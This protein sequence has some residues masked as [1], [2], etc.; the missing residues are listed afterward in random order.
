MNWN[1]TKP[2]YNVAEVKDMKAILVNND[3]SLRWD[4]V[5]NPIIGE[6]DCLVNPLDFTDNPLAEKLVYAGA[7]GVVHAPVNGGFLAAA[8]AFGEGEA[9]LGRVDEYQL[10][11]LGLIGG[12]VLDEDH[13]SQ[14]VVLVIDKI[15]GDAVVAVV[16]V[17]G[18][19][20][21]AGDHRGVHKALQ[22]HAFHHEGAFHAVPQIQKL[23]AVALLVKELHRTAVTA[24]DHRNAD[25]HGFVRQ[26]VG[27]KQHQAHETQ[28]GRNAQNLLQ[29]ASLLSSD[30]VLGVFDVLKET[31]HSCRGRIIAKTI[32][33]EESV[34]P[35]QVDM[36]RMRAPGVYW[37]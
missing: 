37:V 35:A 32:R 11:K 2:F 9:G 31:G 26:G 14:L 19:G 15:D 1:C 8:P 3:R 20:I 17:N 4:D 25:L 7:V 30:G 12:E 18:G 27:P 6:E 10:G 16:I 34:A 21:L 13:R 29:S 22:T 23:H 5:P 24:G 36:A 33:R 28:H